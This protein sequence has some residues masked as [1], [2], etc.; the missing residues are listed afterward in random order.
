[1]G[2][3]SKDI[4]SLEDLLLQ[5]LG[6]MYYAENQIL[7]ALPQMMEKAENAQLKRGFEQHL[8]ETEE[9]VRRLDQAFEL[10]E[11]DAKGTKCPAIDGIISEAE[12]LLGE[13]AEA[14]VMNVAL[15]GAA[16]AV[17]HYEISR[18]GSII[19]WATE[20]GHSDLANLLKDTLAEEKATDRKLTLMAEQRINPHAKEMT[21]EGDARGATRKKSG[22][23]RQASRRTAASRRKRSSRPTARTTATKS[24]S[25]SKKSGRQA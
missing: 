13:I 21:Q 9:Q 12:D 15:I 5:T 10:L 4:R 3:F 25:R 18:Y 6:D 19:A 2:L 1:M 7:K 20:L 22:T 17:E 24:K 16:Q 11:H 14:D 23:R 8:H